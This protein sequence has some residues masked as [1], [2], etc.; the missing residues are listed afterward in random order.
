[1]LGINI[2]AGEPK[3]F[4]PAPGGT[5]E[6]Y[7][8]MAIIKFQGS[9]FREILFRFLHQLSEGDLSQERKP[10]SAPLTLSYRRGGRE[11]VSPVVYNRH[12]SRKNGPAAVGN[13]SLDVRQ[14]M[15]M[16][17]AAVTIHFH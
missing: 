6:T 14:G 10:R 7:D 9:H 2:D 1:M 5:I 11:G 16:S 3:S 4:G 15:V 17:R 12:G 13:G 8:H